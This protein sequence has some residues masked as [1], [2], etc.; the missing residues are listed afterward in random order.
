M[1]NSVIASIF[2]FIIFPLL[3]CGCTNDEDDSANDRWLNVYNDSKANT[4]IH[5]LQGYTY[6]YVQNES[7]ANGT[8]FYFPEE[9]II[10]DETQYQ[11]NFY[12]NRSTSRYG[13]LN[14]SWTNEDSFPKVI[15]DFGG[16]IFGNVDITAVE[17]ARMIIQYKVRNFYT[18][19]IS[20]KGSDVYITQK[21]EYNSL[22]INN[23]LYSAK[24]LRVGKG[25][26][27]GYNPNGGNTNGDSSSSD[28]REENF[29]YDQYTDKVDVRFYFSDRVSSA[30]I[31][32]GTTSSCTS[33]NP[34]CRP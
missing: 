3:F 7:D 26:L 24:L 12:T 6:K 13:V 29:E 5:L 14:V 15:L 20:F 9:T 17:V 11:S 2:A 1:K 27:T 8:L 33:S 16:H 28:F 34:H 21:P 4:L 22:G 25:N 31:K 32:Y 18:D 19:E 10:N 30:T 23:T